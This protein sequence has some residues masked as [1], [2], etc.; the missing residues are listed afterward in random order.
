MPEF[1]HEAIR[2]RRRCQYVIWRIDLV[3]A[4][5]LLT[6]PIRILNGVNLP[7]R[8]LAQYLGRFDELIAE[9]QR[10]FDSFRQERKPDP[11]GRARSYTEWVCTDKARLNKWETN[12]LNLVEL[13]VRKGTKL[14]EQVDQL[15]DLGKSRDQ[16]GQFVSLL[17]G[18]R[19][20]LERGFLRQP[21]TEGRI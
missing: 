3:F 8:L 18:L 20:D 6:R 10:V 1:A 15:A 13:F 4:F 21:F 11:Y 5:F 19:E 12:I 7:K 14:K 2:Q 9:G 16:V 17:K